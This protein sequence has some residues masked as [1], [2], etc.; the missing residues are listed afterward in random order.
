VNYE[1]SLAQMEN[2]YGLPQGALTDAGTVADFI[3]KD[4]STSEVQARVQQGFQAVAYAAP[5][6]RQAFT[7]Y[8]GPNGD[9]ALA[10][11]FLDS[12]KALPLLEQQA[13]AAQFGGQAGMGG[14]AMSQQDAMKLAQLGVSPSTVSSGLQ[15]LQQTQQLFDQNVTEKPG[16]TEGTTGVEAQFGLS[17]QATQDVANREAQRKAD[18]AGG[19]QAYI[20]QHGAAGAGAA[21]PF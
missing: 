2:Q 11:Y 10:H 6:V 20:D 16:V 17:A 18:F 19:G 3:G 15:Q 7:A 21:H 14:I 8:F 5:E 13:T 1:D 4:I 12:S 9:G